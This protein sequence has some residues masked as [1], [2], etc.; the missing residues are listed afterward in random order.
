MMEPMHR[1][2]QVTFVCENRKAIEHFRQL[3]G[4]EFTLFPHV[5]A[6]PIISRVD[7]GNKEGEVTLGSLGS[8]RTEKGSGLL[9]QMAVSLLKRSDRP[10][11]KFVIQ[12]INARGELAKK[13]EALVNDS[14][15]EFID[16]P[17][18]TDQY[19]ACLR[20]LDGLVLPYQTRH[21][22]DRVSRVATEAVCLGLPFIYPRNT[23]LEDVAERCGAGV[24]FEDG[25]AADLERAV[26]EFA[27][28]KTELQALAAERR[29]L[30]RRY[31]SPDRFKT[32]LL[33]QPDE[34][35][36]MAF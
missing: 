25:N 27:A 13:A 20:T 2:G 21:Y 3:C 22:Y 18:N 29:D 17:L 32:L 34:L 26:I 9:Q 4:L 1:S 35:A 6:F 30:A 8:P 36:A 7:N 24:G 5:V 11:V 19:L 23:W 33:R 10:P 31:H 14:R 28:R 12:W 15:V 16:T